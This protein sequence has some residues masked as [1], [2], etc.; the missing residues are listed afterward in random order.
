MRLLELWKGVGAFD[1]SNSHKVIDLLFVVIWSI[2]DYP[3]LST[4][5]GRVTEGYYSCVYLD[6]NPYQRGSGKGVLYWASS[7]RS[8]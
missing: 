8:N 6:N 4:L 7:F 3:I 2:H 1:A 5:V